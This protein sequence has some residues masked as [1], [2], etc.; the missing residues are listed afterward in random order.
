MGAFS[1]PPRDIG[2]KIIF[3]RGSFA[4]CS[5]VFLTLTPVYVVI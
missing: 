1:A 4:F 3:L 2:G 5:H